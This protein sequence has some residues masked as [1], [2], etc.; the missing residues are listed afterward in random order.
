MWE[1]SVAIC[2]SHYK[3]KTTIKTWPASTV[4]GSCTLTAVETAE[5]VFTECAAK[6]WAKQ[7]VCLDENA[8]THSVLLGF[9]NLRKE[10]PLFLNFNGTSIS[11]EQY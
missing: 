7:S 11:N 5:H 1:L 10:V 3:T 2:A 4:P 9:K 8:V 6:H